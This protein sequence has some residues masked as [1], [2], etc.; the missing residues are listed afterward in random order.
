M[1]RF[2]LLYVVLLFSIV[3]C[4]RITHDSSVFISSKYIE[5]KITH[6]GCFGKT[7]QLLQI[8]GNGSERRMTCKLLEGSIQPDRDMKFTVE[9]EKILSELL[10]TAFKIQENE[11]MSTSPCNEQVGFISIYSICTESF[12]CAEFHGNCKIDSLIKELLL[13]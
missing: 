4:K 13:P 3:S 10:T 8:S 6:I 12:T 1:K 5:M 9:K 7:S 2:F 11:L